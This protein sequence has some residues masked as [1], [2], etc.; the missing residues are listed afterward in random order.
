VALVKTPPFD[1][2]AIGANVRRIVDTEGKERVLL[3]W[4]GGTKPM[5]VFAAI[6][7]GNAPILY[8]D[9]RAGGVMVGRGPFVPLPSAEPL[10]MDEMFL[11]HADVKVKR[12]LD[13]VYRSNTAACIR[14]LVKQTPRTIQDFIQYK[15]TLDRLQKTPKRRQFERL[16]APINGPF[17]DPDKNQQIQ[18]SMH[19]DGL[20]SKAGGFQPTL[21][22]LN[23]LNG[24]WWEDFVFGVL[25]ERLEKLVPGRCLPPSMNIEVLWG[26]STTENELDIAFLYNDQ[27]FHISCTTA[28]ESELE[29]RRASAIEFAQRFGGSFARTMIASTSPNH[30]LS[31]VAVR[32]PAGIEMPPWQVWPYANQVDDLLRRWLGVRGR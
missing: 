7:V 27:L 3:N 5:S 31:R 24:F 32:N 15:N 21:D 2:D 23:Y 29:K 19:A 20:M 28:A 22:G 16:N 14:K 6:E 18:E 17:K 4:T 25:C 30:I 26:D 11:L 8:Y 10:T 9:N 1:A 12:S 13:R